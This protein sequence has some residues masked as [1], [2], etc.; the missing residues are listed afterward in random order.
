M[1]MV[2]GSIPSA[3]SVMSASPAVP[4][5]APASLTGASSSPSPGSPAAPAQAARHGDA[6]T[7]ATLLQASRVDTLATF[8]AVQSALP[9]LQVPLRPELNPP[10]WELGHI[11]WFQAY[12][13]NRFDAWAQ[14]TAADPDRPRRPAAR[15][16][17]DALYDS[18]RVPH[19]SRWTLPLPDADATRGD[20]ARQLDATLALLDQV[21]AEGR[22]QGAEADAVLY[23][24]RL[25]L[26]H[27]DM[28]HEAA[29]YMAQGL[30]IPIADARWQAPCLPEPPPPLALP[31]TVWR[32]GR[33]PAARGF[34]FDNECGQTT[35]ALA[36]CTI[37]AQ[38]LRW[39]EFLLFAEQGGYGQP[40]WWTDAGWSWRQATGLEAPRGLRRAA[41]GWQQWRHGHWQALDLTEPACHLSA[42]EALAWCR[43]A[44]R[45][46][47]TEA[48]WTHAAQARPE[49]FRWGDVWEWTASPFLPWPGFTPHPYRDYSAPWFD[50]RP[51]LKGASYMTQP[52]MRHPD[53][54]NFFPPHRHDVPAGF[55]TCADAA[56]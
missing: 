47:P 31:A 16:E 51:V 41:P 10:L 9:D 28:H 2:N 26:L 7:L 37:D 55:R 56:V 13:L 35:Q 12:W 18:S 21:H 44:G 24:F 27:E 8:A 11:G 54:R 40:R 42:H 46:L 43:W 49:A 25:A 36:A 19:D 53:Y 34:A 3:A 45:R 52:R 17:A 1:V 20:L 39:A 22:D 15:A 4:G 14:G 33:A 23:F 29:L 5:A 6:T 48:E 32:A 30:G 38:V 50:G